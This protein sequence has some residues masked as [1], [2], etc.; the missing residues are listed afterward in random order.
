MPATIS[1]SIYKYLKTAIIEGKFKPN[2]RIQEKDIA[3]QFQASTTPV[4]EAFRRLSAEKFIIINARKDVIVASASPEEIEELFEVVRVLDT[5]ATLKALKRLNEKDLNALQKMTANLTAFYKKKKIYEYVKEN[6]KFHEKIWK[7][8]G[9]KFLYQ[10][11]V[12]LGEKYTF[13]G[14][15]VF[16]LSDDPNK[17]PS[18]LNRSYEDHINLMNAIK[19]KDAKAVELILLSH[20]GKGFLKKEEE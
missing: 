1:E 11:L 17:P 8:C 14:N 20:W 18:F 7:A 15:Q 3:K 12:N 5:F 10:S 9:N 16:F 4:R 2:Q 19:K 13:Y 6:L